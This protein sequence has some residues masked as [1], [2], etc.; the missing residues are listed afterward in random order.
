MKLQNKSTVAETGKLYRVTIQGSLADDMIDW[1]GGMEMH[2]E[3]NVTVLEGRMVDQSELQ[4]L[5]RKIHDLHLTLISVETIFD[6]NRNV[7]G[8]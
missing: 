1:F 4:G 3:D 2:I 6:E 7:K 5:L 8:K